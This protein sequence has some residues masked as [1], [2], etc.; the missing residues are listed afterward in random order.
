MDKKTTIL[1]D[2]DYTLFDTSRFVETL[3][4][5]PDTIDYKVF[6]YP[7]TLSFIDYAS[8][9]GDLTLFSEGEPEFQKEKIEGTGISS[10]FKGGTKIFPSYTKVDE[11]LKMPKDEKTIL[12]DDKPDVVDMAMKSGIFVIRVRRGKFSGDETK[13]SP[14]FV[15]DSLSE[16]VSENLL[17][18]I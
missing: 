6:L 10:K 13:E 7:D 8:R 2:F 1:I 5:S 4:K 9:F 18:R 11:L 16:I 17:N 3:E 12:I 15:V 14:K